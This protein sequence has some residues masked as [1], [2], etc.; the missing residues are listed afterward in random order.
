MFCAHCGSQ[1]GDSA[2]F[3]GSCGT[4]IERP[5]AA[6]SV[7]QPVEPS[8][9]APPAASPASSAFTQ[10]M[11][12]IT[13]QLRTPQLMRA[14]GIALGIGLAAAIG[15]AL[16]ALLLITATVAMTQSDNLSLLSLSGITFDST[17]AIDNLGFLVIMALL[18][19]WGTGGSAVLSAQALGVMNVGVSITAPFSLVGIALICGA[20]FGAFWASRA[21]AQR[22][23]AVNISAGILVGL[24]TAVVF[25]VIGLLCSVTASPST[26]GSDMVSASLS[27]VTPRTFFMTLLVA[28]AG[29][30]AGF[31]LSTA[32]PQASNGFVAAWRWAH[33][34]RGWLRTVID[35]TWITGLWFTTIAV[36]LL[37]ISAVMGDSPWLILLIPVLF[38]ALVGY[39]IPLVSLGTISAAIPNESTG[40]L[41]IMTADSNPTLRNMLLMGLVIYVV[42]MAYIA[43]RIGARNMYDPAN[44]GW[45]NT[46]QAPLAVL[47]F[48][49]VA[50]W[51]FLPISASY[52]VAV[53]TITPVMVYCLIAA[54]WLFAAQAVAV[55]C[56]DT[57]IRALPGLW[58]L[59]VGATVTVPATGATATSATAVPAAA[60]ASPTVAT[61]HATPATPSTSVPATSSDS[62]PTQAIPMGIVHTTAD[63]SAAQSPPTATPAAP[64]APTAPAS[65][66]APT[67]PITSAESVSPKTRHNIIIGVAIAVAIVVLGIGYSIV[68]STIFSAKSAAEKYVSMIADGDFDGAQSIVAPQLAKNQ[69]LLLNSKAASKDT[70][71]SNVHISQPTTKDGVTTVPFS[72]ALNG[73]THENTVSVVKEGRRYGI[74]DNWVVTKPLTETITVTVPDTVHSIRVNDVALTKD[75][76]YQTQTGS[77]TFLV[78]P[79]QYNVSIDDNDYYE[80]SPIVVDTA[81]KNTNTLHVE[82]TAALEEKINDTI[83][84]QLDT[85]TKSKQAVPEGCPYLDKFSYSSSSSRYR[86]FSW[87]ITKYPEV[88][89]IDVDTGRFS[90]SS[91][92]AKV[93]YEEQWLSKWE[94]E[95]SNDYF[96]IYGSFALTDDGIVIT[97][98]DE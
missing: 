98:S 28:G 75:N 15:M 36:V 79:G 38:P 90:T 37:L 43:L 13:T 56:A 55:L 50:I 83:K 94:P 89:S 63:P 30:C 33:G 3:C 93:A 53:A 44:G 35:A 26:F 58:K 81:V 4:R 12:S 96:S 74:F 49:F 97:V 40:F 41:S 24:A 5:T 65:P 48:W 6:Q 10:H 91:G 80:A 1:V 95:E 7:A 32:I 39:L 47:G 59:L 78:Y 8:S 51:L 27:I 29:A 70:T 31:S 18:L 86:N 14:M 46:W 76:A 64:K 42:M 77:W 82:A 57:V 72:Y 9:T 88:T 19:G 68:N 92:T 69:T 84:E 34:V 71:I 61:P 45:R 25:M 11:S 73:E 21:I 16:I 23:R 17:S 22:T 60:S 54:I 52:S 2:K 62:V 67:S 20:A 66:A 85:C 87:N